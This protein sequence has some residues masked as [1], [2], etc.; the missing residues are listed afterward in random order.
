MFPV[1]K[2]SWQVV[3]FDSQSSVLKPTE[4]VEKLRKLALSGT[5]DE[6]IVKLKI[7][8]RVLMDKVRH[9]LFHPK[10]ISSM[11][12]ILVS[13]AGSKRARHKHIESG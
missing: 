13:I 1:S 5:L 7:G 3:F 10:R 6:S 2:T 9:S 11:F 4:R 8:D 12:L